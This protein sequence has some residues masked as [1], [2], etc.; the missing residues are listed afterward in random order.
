MYFKRSLVGG[1]ITNLNGKYGMNYSNHFCTKKC[2]DPAKIKR[3]AVWGSLGFASCGIFLL[4]LHHSIPP[5]GGGA[6][7]P[8]EFQADF[9]GP[10]LSGLFIHP[11]G[12]L[13]SPLWKTWWF[14][15]REQFLRFPGERSPCYHFSHPLPQTGI[16]TGSLK[17]SKALGEPPQIF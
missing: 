15:L 5:C 6:K 17:A 4:A 12:R 14:S 8:P 16:W 2:R 1:I 10:I 11:R 3:R 7:R 9:R 13:P